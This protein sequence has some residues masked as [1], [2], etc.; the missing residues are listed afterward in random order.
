MKD[1][2]FI[3]WSGSNDVA[4]RVKKILEN[5]YNYICAIGGNSENTSS[6]ASV[7]DTVI[8]QMRSCNQAIIIF[9]NN[10]A[11]T[12][13]D[14]LFFEL[15][16]SFAM[17]GAKKIHCVK[18]NSDTIVLPSDFDNAFVDP[19]NCDDSPDDFA[20]G[21]V[22]YFMAR[23]KMSVNENKMFLI[24]NRYLIHE[25]IS[26]H[27]SESGSKCSDYELAQYVLYYIQAAMMFED[28]PRIYE[29]ILEF[30]R[31]HA[32]NFSH[33]LEIA[34]NVVLAFAELLAAVKEY[35]ENHDVYI[36]E[37][38]FFEFKRTY[39]HYLKIVKDDDIGIF[40]EWIKLFINQH[41]NFAHML[42]GNNVSVDPEVREGAYK[43]SVKYGD[44]ALEAIRAL[45]QTTFSKEN[46]DDRGLLSLLKAYVT[47]NMYVCN[48]YFGDES[49]VSWLKESV[50]ER[51]YLKNSYSNG[52]IDSQ[53]YNNFC[54]EYYLALINYID[55]IEEIGEIDSFDI[56][57]YKKKIKEYLK[58]MEKN[59]NTTAYLQKLRLWA[60]N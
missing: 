50:E 25:K 42:F 29:E 2:V 10:K 48:K 56:I 60:E 12:V 3:A 55:E 16:Y 9:Q 43:T 53:I 1:R 18:R 11:G 4:V 36:D 52:T 45:E 17:Y 15:G 22:E 35:P 58:M 31:K 14:N 21:I 26:C 19:I 59:N 28:V 24:D 7:G 40:D 54:M 30:K 27:Y 39:T 23:Q 44:I 41:L 37:D 6:M 38:T 51:E 5:D 8:R 57:M 46:H 32:F 33:E 49:A 47:R 20:K 34:V 13:S